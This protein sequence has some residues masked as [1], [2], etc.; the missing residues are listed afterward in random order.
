MRR[1]TRTRWDN[2]N[3]VIIMDKEWWKKAKN[4]SVY[5]HSFVKFYRM[6]ILVLI[7][8]MLNFRKFLVVL[9]FKRRPSE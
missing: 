8:A 7:V 2:S 1:E 4:V 3:G 5:L 6:Y 9:S